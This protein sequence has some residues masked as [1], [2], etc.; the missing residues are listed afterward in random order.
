MASIQAAF[1]MGA[2]GAGCSTSQALPLGDCLQRRRGP[3]TLATCHILH[4]HLPAL[5]FPSNF[6]MMLNKH[7]LVEISVGKVE[8]FG[9]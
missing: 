9:V 5:N 2:G 7:I 4:F 8:Q 6:L 3:M 1:A